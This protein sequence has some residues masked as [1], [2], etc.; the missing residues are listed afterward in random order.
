MKKSIRNIVIFSIVAVGCGFLGAFLNTGNPPQDPM[1]GLGALIWLVSPVIANILL[2]WLGGDGWKDFGLKPNFK[3]GWKWYLVALT[4]VPVVVILTMGLGVVFKAISLSGFSQNGINAFLPLVITGFVGSMMKNMF[5]EF[6]WRG[7]LTPRLNA[8][9]L[10]PFVNS[11]LTGF[12]WAGWHIPYYL[13]FLDRAVLEAHTTLSVP[14]FILLAFLLLPF[15]ALAYGELRLLSKSIW[16]SWLL[17]NIANALSLPLLSYGFV[18][19]KKG[20]SGVLLS[21][22]SEGIVYSLLIGLAGFWM[23]RFRMRKP[24][25]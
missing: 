5:E 14:A 8:I 6:A 12:V 15:Q 21:P 3:Q 1:Q 4:I 10:H 18:T 24:K 17:H 9:K 16:P 25:N 11:I 19:L 7:Y 22:G 20:F 13:F 2:R 23:Y